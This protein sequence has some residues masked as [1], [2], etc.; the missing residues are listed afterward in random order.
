MTAMN[1]F[2]ISVASAL[3]GILLS[4]FIILLSGNS[5]FTLFHYLIQ[6]T[7]GNLRN[8]GNWINMSSIV[9]LTGLSVAFSYRAGL[10]NIGAEGQFI[11]GAF[12]SAYLGV[13]TNWGAIPIL[14]VSVMAGGLYGIIPGVLK[15]Y[16]RV[17]E[18]VVTIMLNWIALEFVNGFISEK[19][20]GTTNDTVTATVHQNASLHSEFL[21]NIFQN[22]NMNWGFIFVIIAIIIYWFILQKT[23][24][25]YE[26]KA[27][28]F[29]PY[30]AKY[31]GIKDKQKLITTLTISGAFAGLAGAI[32]T[33]GIVGHYTAGSF[34]NYGFDGITVAFLGQMSATGILL[35]GLLLGG[36]RSAGLL[37]QVV[38][39]EIIDITIAVILIF[40]ALG[41]AIFRKRK[42]QEIKKQKGVENV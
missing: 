34:L 35:G 1:K 22:D 38:P 19:F 23:R 4:S 32:Y 3:I 30:A 7:V 11:V 21:S 2:L 29:N 20:H 6:G 42:K 18:V 17:S 12:M 24:L 9:I 27:V 31:A 28:G 41:P 36:L 39:K 16:Y 26:I 40:V 10:F 37:I 8:T 33:L 14:I 5:F 15:A 25:G 13:V